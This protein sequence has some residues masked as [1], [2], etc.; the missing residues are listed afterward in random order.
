MIQNVAAVPPMSRAQPTL[1]D[2]LPSTASPEE[3][4]RGISNTNSL[5]AVLRLRIS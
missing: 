4:R 5:G 3:S 2:V 1:R